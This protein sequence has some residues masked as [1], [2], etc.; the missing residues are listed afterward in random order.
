M[1]DVRC[2]EGHLRATV[3][4]GKLLIVCPQCSHAARK[5][6][7]PAPV[8]HAWTLEDLVRSDLNALARS[9]PNAAGEQLPEGIAA[10][11]LGR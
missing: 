7:C 3:A 11:C 1:I 8:M 10:L 2:E 4:D 5:A 6:G 9:Q